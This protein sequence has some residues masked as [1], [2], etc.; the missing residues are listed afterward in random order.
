[1][2]VTLLRARSRALSISAHLVHRTHSAARVT[3]LLLGAGQAS[4]QITTPQEACVQPP[5]AAREEAQHLY[6]DGRDLLVAERWAETAAQLEKAVQLDTTHALAHYGL[7]QA[8]LSLKKA[9]EALAA[10][11]DSR[12]AYRCILS[13]P[14][15]QAE[16]ERMR[17]EEESSLR[18]AM[19]R[20]ERGH[21]QRFG[22]KL[23]E[24]NRLPS[25]T[26]A[27]LDGLRR[28]HA[29]ESR[30]V[31]LRE[32][33]GRSPAEP[34]ELAF[35]L[36]NAYFQSGA[37]DEAER[38]FRAALTARPD[39][40]DVRHNLA[41]VLLATGRLDEA[42]AEMKRAENAGVPVHPRLREEIETQRDA[43]GG[44]PP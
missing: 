34:P 5:V 30:L 40:G 1:M 28:L 29:M 9:P 18:N 16:L 37:V 26:D 41:V 23:Q 12:A 20:L 32:A 44:S 15:A 14:E 2:T 38:E 11:L 36:G 3:V 22:M 19:Q 33:R 43:R 8:R 35:A 42:E 24:V 39:W 6:E 31:E 7:G 10:F 4:A 27:M 13:S 25:P 17:A 21:L